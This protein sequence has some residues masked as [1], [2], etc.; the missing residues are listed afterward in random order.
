MVENKFLEKLKV[1]IFADGA[2]IE[3]IKLLDKKNFIKG[4]TT[5][6][7]LMKKSGVSDYKEYALS[8]LN[9]IKNKP[10]SFEV[11]SDDLPEMQKQAEEIARWSKNISVKIP[12]TNT[13]QVSTAEII[14]KLSDKGI[15]C[16]ITAIFTEEQIKTVLEALNESTPAILS[17]FAGRIADAGQDPEIIM[18]NCVKL[19]KVKPKSEV[20]WAST[21][22]LYNIFQAEK[23]G[24]HIITVPHSILNKL[25]SLGRDLNEYS[26]ETVKGFY[27]DAKAAG[28]KIET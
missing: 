24:C 18:K 12:V 27:K 5:N 23:I 7:S 15:Q 17:V 8:V 13:K 3:G 6:P 19:A 26:L 2:D 4:F 20:L 16:N 9:V 22:E 25:D 11:F 10:I 1:K 21:R 28:Y 14:K